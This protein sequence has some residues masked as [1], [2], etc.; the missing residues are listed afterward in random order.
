MLGPGRRE[1][2]V[3]Q[4]DPEAVPHRLLDLVADIRHRRRLAERDD[5]KTV[6]HVDGARQ[7][8]HLG[9]WRRQAVTWRTT[10]LTSRNVQVF[11]FYFTLPSMSSHI[12]T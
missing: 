10:P 2:R 4:H 7:T 8:T 11:I 12:I 3:V 6:R 1:V 5:V 9:Q